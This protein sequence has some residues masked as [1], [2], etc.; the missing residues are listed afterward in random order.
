MRRRRQLASLDAVELRSTHGIRIADHVA[1]GHCLRDREDGHRLG[2]RL[3][4]KLAAQFGSAHA[5]TC[6]AAPLG[7]INAFKADPRPMGVCES[8]LAPSTAAWLA[9][10]AAAACFCWARSVRSC[11]TAAA[12][13]MTLGDTPRASPYSSMNSS[14]SILSSTSGS[15]PA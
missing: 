4:E 3:L 1:I 8:V 2:L 5:A 11:C 9:W 7:F 15:A 14:K 10:A 12:E 6:A 13:R